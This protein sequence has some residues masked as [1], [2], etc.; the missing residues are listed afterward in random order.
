M[1]I[2]AYEVGDFERPEEE[3]TTNTK[4]DNRAPR[5]HSNRVLL[6][7]QKRSEIPK[8]CLCSGAHKLYA[9]NQ[10]INMPLEERRKLVKNNLLCFNCLSPGHQ[11]N[12][13]FGSGCKKC[14][15]KHNT[16]V[17]MNYATPARQDQENQNQD[18]EHVVKYAQNSVKQPI[19]DGHSYAMIIYMILIMIFM[20]IYNHAEPFWIQAHNSTL[21]Q[22][23]V[24]K[25][26]I[27]NL[28]TTPHR[29]LALVLKA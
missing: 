20:A 8:C 1:L 26:Y 9:C 2:E 23:S 5:Q 3:P 7:N 6:T 19:I 4:Y 27:S 29:F 11:S 12:S 21:C 14:G 28:L 10:F 24:L 13:C 15:K 17:H 25:S 22:Y 16:M 18:A